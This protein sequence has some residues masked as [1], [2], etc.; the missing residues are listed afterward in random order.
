MRLTKKRVTILL[1]SAA[2]VG[3]A[4]S[5]VARPGNHHHHHRGHAVTAAG[6]AHASASYKDQRYAFLR[7]DWQRRHGVTL[8]ARRHRGAAAPISAVG[9]S[10]GNALVAEARKY[11][12]TNPTGRRSLWCGAFM[13]MVLRRHR[14]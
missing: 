5:A 6:P 7:N 8:S 12:G 3:L 13:D 11:I 1:C 9:G 10:S 4:G 14:P 2:L